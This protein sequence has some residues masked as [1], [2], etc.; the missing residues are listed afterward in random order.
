MSFKLNSFQQEVFE[1][2]REFNRE[3]SFQY[4]EW[5]K[6]K[7][8][9]SVFVDQP[10]QTI[11]PVE[12]KW[13]PLLQQNQAAI[14]ENCYSKKVKVR[15][16]KNGRNVATEDYA[17]LIVDIED[18]PL[19]QQIDEVSCSWNSIAGHWS[20]ATV[21]RANGKAMTLIQTIPQFLKRSNPKRKRQHGMAQAEPFNFSKAVY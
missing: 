17:F 7:Q 3:A 14:P 8:V 2:I 10:T 9:I 20:T 4:V 5:V 21:T 12:P 11:K 6:S 19:A 13:K 16:T 15:M 1:A 18:M